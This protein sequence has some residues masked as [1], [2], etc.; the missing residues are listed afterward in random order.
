MS[1]AAGKITEVRKGPSVR[2][3]RAVSVAPLWGQSPLHHS[4]HRGLLAHCTSLG[5]LVTSSYPT[6]LSVSIAEAV[7]QVGIA[8][9][10]E[11][12]AADL[13]AMEG[14]GAGIDDPVIVGPLTTMI[15]FL[16]SK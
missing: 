10:T 5:T 4:V 9:V 1:E 11:A 8:S 15:A 2:K 14:G 7:L 3:A 12:T 13:H 6:A 16:F